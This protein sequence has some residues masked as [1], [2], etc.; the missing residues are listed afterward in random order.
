MRAGEA[1]SKSDFVAAREDRRV[2]LRCPPWLG[3]DIVSIA[4]S[5]GTFPAAVV[6]GTRNLGHPGGARGDGR[7]GTAPRQRQHEIRHTRPG[8]GPSG[9]PAFARGGCPRR[10]LGDVAPGF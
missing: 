3:A 1:W 7:P 5:A 10:A 4:T 6:A 2:A 8:G 9:F